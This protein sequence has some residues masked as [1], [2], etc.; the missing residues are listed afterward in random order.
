MEQS[1]ALAQITLTEVQSR[2]AAWRKTKQH[3]SRIPEELWTAAVMLNQEHSLCKISKALSLSYTDLKE[4]AA[5][6]QNTL[7]VRSA[8]LSM[9]FIPI[10]IAPSHAAECIVEMEHRNGNKMRMHFK[11]QVDLDLQSFAE[12]FWHGRI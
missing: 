9:N 10:D 11:G 2:F 3:R 8:S 5:K 1:L 4:R 7:D 6:F 12:S